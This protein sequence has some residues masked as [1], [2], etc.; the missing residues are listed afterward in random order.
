MF[1]HFL[2]DSRSVLKDILCFSLLVFAAAYWGIKIY[3]TYSS[4]LNPGQN[5]WNNESYKAA[6]WTKRNTNPEDVIAMKDAGHFSFFSERNVIN[7]DGLVN[8]FVYQEVLKNKKLSKYL[9]DNNVKY[10]SQ[11]ALWQ[12]EDV[13]SG[14][15]DSLSLNFM[16]HK[17]SAESDPVV[18]YKRNEVYRSEP[19]FDSD[20]KTVFIIWKLKP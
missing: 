20:N 15:Y 13:T 18:L 1:N 2:K 6:L 16:S 7:L 19:Y 17:Y 14:N 4:D 3:S 5:N 8:N 11:H 12:R 9:D 10:L